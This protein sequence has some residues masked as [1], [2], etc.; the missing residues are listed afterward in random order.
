MYISVVSNQNVICV[1]LWFL[2]NN[3]YSTFIHNK[4]S[5]SI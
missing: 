3:T 1:V 4:D 2:K 5:I